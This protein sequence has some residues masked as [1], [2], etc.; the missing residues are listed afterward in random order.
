MPTS[1]G[2]T[3]GQSFDIDWCLGVKQRTPKVEEIRAAFG[4]ERNARTA[5][6]RRLAQIL[7]IA[8]ESLGAVVE[9]H[10][11]GP[12][13]GSFLGMPGGRVQKSTV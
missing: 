7:S 9:G 5:K 4:V 13:K 10:R 12:K 11:A 2:F 6:E 3:A 8:M 1:K